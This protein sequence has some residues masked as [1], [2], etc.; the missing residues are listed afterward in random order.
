MNSVL[1]MVDSRDCCLVNDVLGNLVQ[2]WSCLFSFCPRFGANIRSCSALQDHISRHLVGRK[3]TAYLE[4][5]MR[6]KFSTF[7]SKEDGYAV[8]VAKRTEWGHG[9]GT[10]IVGDF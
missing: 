3:V 6:V 9:A 5:A 8:D 7:M 4:G 2:D 10:V 1:Q